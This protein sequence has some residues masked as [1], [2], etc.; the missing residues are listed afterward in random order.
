MALV[1]TPVPG[2]SGVSAGVVFEDGVGETSDFA[3][4]AYF[5]QAGYGIDEEPPRPE[6]VDPPDP[7]ELGND[8]DG[9]VHVGSLLRDAAVDPKPDDFLAP[10]NA[11]EANPHGS[12]VVA[13]GVHGTPPGPIVPGPVAADPDVQDAVES[14]VAEATLSQGLPVPTVTEQV[15]EVNVDGLT[16]QSDEDGDQLVA[17]FTEAWV[18]GS[19]IDTIKAALEDLDGEERSAKAQE[20]LDYE[21]DGKARSTLLAYLTDLVVD[22]GDLPATDGDLE[23]GDAG[24][25]AEAE[26][27]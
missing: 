18:H 20:V 27:T 26:P 9:I 15:A 13:P 23:A 10:T 25:S 24:T 17:P 4:L 7:R 5:R 19:S 16:L 3:A 14:A 2:W 6:R 22:P 1:Y 11:G 12:D 8:G 21:Q